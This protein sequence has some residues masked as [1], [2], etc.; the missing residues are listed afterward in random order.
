MDIDFEKIYD[1][2]PLSEDLKISSFK[3]ELEDGS[4]ADLKIQIS[5][6]SHELMPVVYNL[7]FG[8]VDAKGRINDKAELTHSDYSRVFSTILFDALTY[9]INNKG[10]YLGVDGSDNNRAYLYYRFIQRNY[11]YLSDYFNI[12]GVKYYVRIT[13]FGKRQ[14]ENPFDF[15]D[16]LPVPEKIQ[17]AAKITPDMLYN[18]F[19]FNLK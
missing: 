6:V 14:Y 15:S 18:Y 2:E 9:L 8:P 16:V 7:A 19:I 13:R 10:Q 5:N 12:F 11:D 17:K 1:I 4:F 3:S